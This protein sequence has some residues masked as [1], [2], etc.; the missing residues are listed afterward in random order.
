MKTNH[1][2]GVSKSSVCGLLGNGAV[3]GAVEEGN[4][5]NRGGC[6]Q[7]VPGCVSSAIL[8]YHHTTYSNKSYFLCWKMSKRYWECL[9]LSDAIIMNSSIWWH[10]MADCAFV[11]ITLPSI[12]HW[13][14]PCFVSPSRNMFILL[15]QILCLYASEFLLYI[16]LWFW[17]AE[18]VK[19]WHDGT[20]AEMCLQI[21]QD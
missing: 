9:N 14:P 10:S 16:N 3:L 5:A 8:S 17:H 11:G 4:T 7:H 1:L 2:L 12:L 15:H 13:R 21:E 19:V 6:I 20:D 18:Y